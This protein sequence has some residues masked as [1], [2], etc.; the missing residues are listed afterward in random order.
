M[1]ALLVG[2]LLL[3]VL[4]GLVA[5]MV[6][7]EAAKTPLEHQPVYVV[8][9]AARFIYPQL[10]DGAISRLDHDDIVRILEWEVA[11]LQGVGAVG[12]ASVFPVRVAGSDDAAAFVQRRLAEGGF[13]YLLEDI[14][15]VLY[16]ESTYLI[17]I[18]AIG[19]D[20]EASS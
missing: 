8:E 20:E 15:E 9:E 2:A 13:D 3:A 12:T 5:V 10:G 4:L 1:D 16:H 19:F 6:W 14:K 7:Q 17:D 18:G 11:Y